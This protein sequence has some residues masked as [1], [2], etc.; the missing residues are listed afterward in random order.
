VRRDCRRCIARRVREY[1]KRKRQ[2]AI[3]A[4]LAPGADLGRAA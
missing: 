4:T 3:V 1:R 2:R